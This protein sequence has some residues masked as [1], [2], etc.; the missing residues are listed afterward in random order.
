MNASASTFTGGAR[1]R[2]LSSMFNKFN[3]FSLTQYGRLLYLDTD[4][5]L[6]QPVDKLWDATLRSY[7]VVAAARTTGA[8]R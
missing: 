8:R 6:T 4:V 2:T 5:L 3:V 7:E 1:V